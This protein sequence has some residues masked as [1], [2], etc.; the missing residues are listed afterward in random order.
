MK[1]LLLIMGILLLALLPSIPISGAPN[2]SSNKY[3][4]IVGNDSKQSGYPVYGSTCARLLQSILKDNAFMQRNI[5]MLLNSRATKQDIID[6][7]NW[8]RSVETPSSEVIVAFFGHGGSTG[9]L[10]SDSVIT[11]KEIKGL[12]PIQSLKQLIIIDTCA[13]GGAIIEGIDGITLSAPNRIVLT[14]VSGEVGTST[15]SGHLTDWCRGV[16]LKGI[17][18]GMADWNNDGKVSIQE[19]ARFQGGISDNYGQEFFL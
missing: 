12:A 18:E 6:G 13:S 14:S 9:I 16:L 5:K 10:L 7:L 11:H 8:L 2:T 17:K 3:A 4:V 15:Y 1:K 19:A